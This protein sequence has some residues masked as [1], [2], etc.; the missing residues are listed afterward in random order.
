MQYTITVLFEDD[1][2]KPKAVIGPC[3]GGGERW[4]YDKNTNTCAIFLYGGCCGNG[5]KF[6]SRRDCENKCV[7]SPN[8]GMQWGGN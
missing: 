5:N 1:C 7:V 2:E 4:T 3:R 8:Q 6:F